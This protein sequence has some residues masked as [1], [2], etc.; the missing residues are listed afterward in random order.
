MS[1]AH[2][3]YW[4]DYDGLQNAKHQLLKR[5][6][7]GWFP[8]LSSWNG[9]VLYI[10]CHAGRGRHKTGQEGSPII[11]LQTL[12]KHHWRDSIL[13]STEVVFLFFENDKNNYQQLCSEIKVLKPLPKNIVV[14]VHDKDHEKILT[15]EIATIRAKGQQLAPSFAFLDPFGFRL[16]MDLIKDLLSFPK[17]EIMIN[18][19]YRFV[20]MAM[21]HDP[22]SANLDRLF[23]TH[24]WKQLVDIEDPDERSRQTIQLFSN[25]LNA[26]YVRKLDM[27]AT[28]GTL[29]YALL[30]A[31]NHP[32]GLNLM[33]D[34]LWNVTPD[35][36]FYASER[37]SP[38]QL[39]LLTPEPDLEPL[40][41]EIWREFA[42]KDVRVSRMYVWLE[43][44]LFLEKHLRQVLGEY[45][46]TRVVTFDGYS[47]RFGF[48]KNP[49]AH[50]PK[51]RPDSK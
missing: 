37:N 20:D 25:Q 4:E 24:M 18:F 27:R 40:K 3:D 39:V 15:K 28:N 30:H 31:T 6:L 7:G 34:A 50:F 43:D 44:K 21:R 33:K 10:D 26:K 48:N 38:D 32:K 49:V 2:D 35:G 36:S 8:I 47:N 22:Q 51:E 12:I 17:C 14:E 45:R 42:G 41:D 29:K 9:R 19:M 5:Y 23:G 11:A 1:K 16:S 13:N 46:K